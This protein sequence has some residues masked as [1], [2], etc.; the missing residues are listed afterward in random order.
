MPGPNPLDCPTLFGK[1]DDMALSEKKGIISVPAGKCIS[2]T[3]NT[4]EA[5]VCA[6]G[7]TAEIETLMATARMMNPC[8]TTCAVNG[9]GGYWQNDDKSIW[10]EVRHAD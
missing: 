6:P 7:D 8:Q 5:L 4:C 3:Q 9:K 1:W 10:V 2:M